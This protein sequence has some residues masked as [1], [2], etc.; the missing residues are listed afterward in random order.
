LQKEERSRQIAAYLEEGEQVYELFSVMVHSGSAHGGHYYAYIWSFEQEQWLK[1]NDSNVKLVTTEEVKST[2]GGEGRG[3]MKAC[4]NAY[5]LTYRK[6]SALCS[7]Q[8]SLVRDYIRREM[9]NSLEEDKTESEIA[10]N[11]IVLYENQRKI[12][13]PAGNTLLRD[14]LVTALTA[15]SETDNFPTSACVPTAPNA[16]ISL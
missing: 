10:T 8:D 4:A 1:F 7:V 11:I 9:G 16:T 3:V 5:L 14:F 13:K 6:V 2:F 15:M 12:F